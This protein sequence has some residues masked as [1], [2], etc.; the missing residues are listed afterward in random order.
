MI[1]LSGAA[2]SLAGD[3]IPG[4]I[5]SMVGDNGP[6]ADTASSYNFPRLPLV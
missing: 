5:W 1:P 3:S 2:F 4:V 6:V